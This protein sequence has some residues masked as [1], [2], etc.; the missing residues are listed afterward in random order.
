ML[1]H[2]ALAYALRDAFPDAL[3]G[4]FTPE[5]LDVAEMRDVT[6]PR[7]SPAYNEAA[8]PPAPPCT[9]GHKALRQRL[10]GEIGKIM[11]QE[12]ADVLPYFT[13]EEKDAEKELIRKAPAN[14]QGIALLEGQKTRLA[15]ELE[16]RIKN[17][18]PIEPPEAA[19]G[20]TASQAAEDEEGEEEYEEAAQEA[21]E[22]EESRYE[23]ASGLF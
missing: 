6:E 21:A 15:L 14:E 8:P 10:I 23:D 19:S 7:E 13:R 16:S 22:D 12:S 5:E 4:I 17:C 11:T 20:V 3:A 18:K 9:E 2:R 1:K